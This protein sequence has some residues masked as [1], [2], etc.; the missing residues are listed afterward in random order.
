MK[1]A[2]L[3]NRSEFDDL[4]DYDGWTESPPQS[5]NGASANSLASWTRSVSVGEITDF[6]SDFY[7]LREIVVT[8]TNS[9]GNV[10]QLSALRSKHSAVDQSPAIETTM[11]TTV[12]GILHLSDT[13][14]VYRTAPNDNRAFQP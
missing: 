13:D 2:H 12:L 4:D 7:G 11:T 8:A 3:S 1:R 14:F 5:K 6:A 10:Y 9:D